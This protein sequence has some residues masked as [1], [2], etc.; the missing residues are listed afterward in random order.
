MHRD[1]ANKLDMQ[2]SDF[3]CDFTGKAWDGSFP[4][5]EGHQGSLISGDALRVAYTDVV[6]MGNDSMPAGATCVMCLEVRDGPGWQSPMPVGQHQGGAVICRRC[7]QQSASRLDKD[8]DWDWAKP[9]R[10]ESVGA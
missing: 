3:V 1:G 9:A 5:V 2:P 6:L 10:D 4:M 7:I 8:A